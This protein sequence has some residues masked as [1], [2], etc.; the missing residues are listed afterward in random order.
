MVHLNQL[1]TPNNFFPSITLHASSLN[2][3]G[4]PYTEQVR[5]FM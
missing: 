4:P 5:L 3:Y 2:F 1:N